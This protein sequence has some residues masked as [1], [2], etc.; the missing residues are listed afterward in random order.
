MA[1]LKQQ[2]GQWTLN[3]TTL[4]DTLVC[5]IEGLGLLFIFGVLRRAS[6][7]FTGVHR[8]FGPRPPY[9]V[10]A[11]KIFAKQRK[12]PRKAAQ[13][14]QKWCTFTTRTVSLNSST[15]PK[16]SKHNND[17]SLLPCDPNWRFS[18]VS[19]IGLV[20]GLQK[21]VCVHTCKDQ[22]PQVFFFL[23][24]FAHGLPGGL[25]PWTADVVKL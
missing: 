3:A 5:Q 12:F 8:L 4:R 21:N 23:V 7:Y 1:I 2:H 6:R 17:W 14:P 10:N 13:I 16:N 15:N 11:C 24:G 18:T 20:F 19:M 9:C 22:Q 25:A